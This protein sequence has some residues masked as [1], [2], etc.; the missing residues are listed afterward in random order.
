M[1]FQSLIV[2]RQDH[3][4]SQQWLV[5]SKLPG[6]LPEE[7]LLVSNWPPRLLARAPPPPEV[8]R[9]LIVTGPEL[10]PSVRSVATRSPRSC[11]SANCPSNVLSVRSPKTSRPTCG[12]NPPLSWLCNKLQRLTWLAFSR[13]LTC[14]P[15]TP[16]AS[17]SCPRTSNLPAVS[18]ES[19]P[20]L[21]SS[22]LKTTAFF[23]ATTF[24]RKETFVF[25]C[26][27]NLDILEAK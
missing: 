15:S 23:K 18:A 4:N 21:P 2:H 3:V 12:S 20:K 9:S 14:A 13:I 11:S 16:S 25:K 6:N 19:A 8:S 17:P 26:S 5:L 27:Q 24:L 7:R 22:F 10:W 1:G